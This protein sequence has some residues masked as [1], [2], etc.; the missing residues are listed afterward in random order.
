MNNLQYSL[1]FTIFEKRKLQFLFWALHDWKSSL[2][3]CLKQIKIEL[4]KICDP[5]TL[6]IYSLRW[7]FF[8]DVILSA[9]DKLCPDVAEFF[10]VCYINFPQKSEEDFEDAEI[11]SSENDGFLVSN[12]LFDMASFTDSFQSMKGISSG[13]VHFDMD[14]SVDSK[15]HI[16][17]N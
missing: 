4:L 12:E 3:E 14:Y 10:D 7:H 17:Q 1:V 6:K 8:L 15:M 11:N 9:I 5:R 2:F 16:L 13:I